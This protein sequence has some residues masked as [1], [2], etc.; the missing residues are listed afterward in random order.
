MRRTLAIVAAVVVTSGLAIAAPAVA[1]QN[2]LQEARN[3]SSLTKAVTVNG[4]LQ[5]ERQFQTIAD[6]NEGT[7]ASGLPGHT[8]SADYVAKKLRA[9]GYTVTRQKF[10]FAVLARARASHADRDLAEPRESI[11]TATL[12]Y[13]G[14]GDV[15]GTVVPTNDLVIPPPPEPSSTS[16]CEAEDFAPAPADPAI[17]LIQRGTCTFEAKAVNAAAAG[18]DAAI[19]FNEGQPGRDELLTGTLGNPVDHPSRR[20]VVCRRRRTG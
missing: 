3:S 11:E 9:A 8:E 19:I 17:A 18:Y 1:D 13:S 5:H 2:E 7:R 12:D 14:S 15:T 4:I 6:R 20:S 16:G 10:T